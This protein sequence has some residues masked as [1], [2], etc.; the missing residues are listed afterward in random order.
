LGLGVGAQDRPLFPLTEDSVGKL[1]RGAFSCFSHAAA[2]CTAN[3]PRKDHKLGAQV[4]VT[5]TI[6]T[7]RRGA[8]SCVVDDRFLLVHGGFNGSRCL[9]DLYALDTMSSSWSKVHVDCNATQQPGP[10]AL[11]AMCTIANGQSI[12]LH[13]G[14][15]SKTVLSSLT[16]L[17]NPALTEGLTLGLER[18]QLAHQVASLQTRLKQ[19]EVAASFDQNELKAVQNK[20][21]V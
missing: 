17:H 3:L 19:A 4:P 18:E 15:C 5:G 12:I 21:H 16:V 20:H 14:A 1:R 7:A 13:G 8:A 11:H 10:R 9:D 2:G 6:P